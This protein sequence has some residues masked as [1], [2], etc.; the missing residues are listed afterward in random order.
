MRADARAGDSGGRQS[1]DVTATPSV[2]GNMWSHHADL[3]E[4]ESLI[5]T[6]PEGG[7]LQVN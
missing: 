4:I 3:W 6:S 5:T 1:A 2:S 7:K